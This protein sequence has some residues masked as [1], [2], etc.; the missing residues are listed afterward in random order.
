MLATEVSMHIHNALELA[1]FHTSTTY[2]C[3]WCPLKFD[4]VAV[5]LQLFIRKK[6]RARTSDRNKPIKKVKAGKIILEKVRDF[7]LFNAAYSVL[8]IE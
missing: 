7:F 4:M 2:F 5:H 8:V 6:F 1:H 3:T